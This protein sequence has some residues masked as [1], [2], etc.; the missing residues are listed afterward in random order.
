V[1]YQYNGQ[2]FATLGGQQKAQ[3]YNKLNASQKA[4][5]DQLATSQA[6]KA[7]GGKVAAATSFLKSQ[8]LGSIAKDLFGQQQ[9]SAPAP[10]PA[11]APASPAGPNYKA[12]LAE[13][14]A[15][16]KNY[17]KEAE[18]LIAEGKAKVALLEDEQ[19][20]AEKA[21]QLQAQLAI[22]SAVSQKLG[23]MAPTV[24]GAPSSK[25]QIGGTQKFKTGAKQFSLPQIQT[26][27]GLNIPTANT[28]NI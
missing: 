20:Q 21:Q 10:A 14:T 15:A 3:D 5:V 2:F 13:L 27:S 12:Q 4:V 25:M 8:K 1:A 26:A 22:Q 16:S 18:A 17:K 6:L 9:Q 19:L 28:L 24:K 11:P 23:Q 7:T